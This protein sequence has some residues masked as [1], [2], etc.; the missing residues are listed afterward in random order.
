MAGPETGK[1]WSNY[2]LLGSRTANSTQGVFRWGTKQVEDLIELIDVI[3]ALEDWSTTEK[4]GQDAPDG[5]HV[6]CEPVQYSYECF[7][8][9]VS[10]SPTHCSRSGGDDPSSER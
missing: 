2:S 5:P 7:R 10:R 9:H 1:S 6:D 4:F 3:P 8:E